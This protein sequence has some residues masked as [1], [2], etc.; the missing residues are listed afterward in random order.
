MDLPMD[1]PCEADI[2]HETAACLFKCFM[3]RVK[4]LPDAL[5]GI[6]GTTVIC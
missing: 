4:A 1:V 6:C 5:S 2:L 3:G